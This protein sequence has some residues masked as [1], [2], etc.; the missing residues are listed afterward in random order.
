MSILAALGLKPS[1]VVNDNPAQIFSRDLALKLGQGAWDDAADILS[2]AT[3]EGRERILYGLSKDPQCVPLTAKWAQACADSA[4]ANVALGAAII[5]SGWE[6]R[7]SAYAEDVDEAAW[8]PFLERMEDADEPLLRAAALDER[9]AD[10]F[11]WLIHAAIG[12]SDPRA[13]LDGL[14]GRA[15]ERD[16]L[17]WPTHRKYFNVTTDK[18]GGSHEEMFAFA[19]GCSRKAPRGSLLHTLVASAFNDYA[20]AVRGGPEAANVRSEANA[21]K[22]AQALY[23]M[24]D[25]TPETMAQRLSHKE[26][27]SRYALNQF[28]VAC[29]LTGAVRE[30]KAVIGALGGEIEMLPWAWIARDLKEVKNP[31]WVHDRVLREL[32]KAG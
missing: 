26:T 2:D 30:A 13:A 31:A 19:D 14:F 15:C 8:A 18:W 3:D 25:A 4:L 6:I 5:L 9:S 20:L 28:A 27:V 7:G 16:P 32:K 24:L 21:A 23:A 22:V 1:A 11:A 17:H 12:R 10:P 29:Y